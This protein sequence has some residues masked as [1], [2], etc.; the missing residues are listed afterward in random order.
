MQVRFK[1]IKLLVLLLLPIFID[2]ITKHSHDLSHNQAEKHCCCNTAHGGTSDLG[3]WRCRLMNTLRDKANVSLDNIH[4]L[5]NLE[6]QFAN[7]SVH[8]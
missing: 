6:V 3:A 4:S 5:T 1:L 2:G 8:F 7:Q